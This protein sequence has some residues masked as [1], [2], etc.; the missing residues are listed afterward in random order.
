LK[1]C[2]I[3]EKHKTHVDEIGNVPEANEEYFMYQ[4][5]L[6]AW[7]LGAKT[8]S[9]D[10]ASRLEAYVMKSIHEAKVRTTWTLVNEPYEEA[11][12]K[13]LKGILN[14]SEFVKTFLEFE[15]VIVPLGKLNS[16]SQVILKLTCPGIPDIYQGNETW[17][18]SLVDPDNRRLVDYSSR[19]KTLSEVRGF[20][21]SPENSVKFLQNYLENSDDGKIKMFVTA[22]LL[23]LRNQNEDLFMD[24]DYTPLQVEGS[25]GKNLIAFSRKA[26]NRSVV[27]VVSRFFA[28]FVSF[29]KLR[30]GNPESQLEAALRSEWADTSVTLG[31]VKGSHMNVFTGA[32]V[33]LNGKISASQL[34]KEI[35][36]AVLLKK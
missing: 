23:N 3:A 36:F 26:G 32:S 21:E 15:N 29:E 18:F 24:G 2:R 20:L 33:E 35:P 17:D 27:V 30:A 25:H 22:A 13:F 34:F 19:K 6:G 16:L 7:E 12:K 5:L 10:L 9:K 28:K 11:I 14:D 1:T 4:S 8:P 31:D